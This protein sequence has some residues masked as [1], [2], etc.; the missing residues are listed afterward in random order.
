MKGNGFG[1]GLVDLINSE[2][3]VRILLVCY[4]KDGFEIL[5]DWGWDKVLGEMDFDDKNN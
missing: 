4:Y 1:F 2:S 5:I 3:V